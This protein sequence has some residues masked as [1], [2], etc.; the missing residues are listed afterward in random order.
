MKDLTLYRL[1]RYVLGTDLIQKDM[2]RNADI[3]L[4]P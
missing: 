3:S 2:T 1:T 4:T